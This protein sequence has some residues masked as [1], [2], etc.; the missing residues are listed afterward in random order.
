MSVTRRFGLK[1]AHEFGSLLS[2]SE[3]M[4]HEEDDGV[5]EAIEAAEKAIEGL[6]S[7]RAPKHSTR[8]DRLKSG[9]VFLASG[10]GLLASLG[11]LLK[12]CDHSVTE[13]AYN[14]LSES[15]VKLSDQEQK[16]QQDV[17][18]I[19]GYLDGLSRAPLPPPSPGASPPLLFLAD[20]G[21]SFQLRTFSSKPEPTPNI[22]FT[23]EPTPPPP[24]QVHAPSAPVKPP[25]FTAATK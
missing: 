13:S 16:T 12:T 11:A 19:R 1:K 2:Y 10:A 18:S 25:S 20:A 3:Q 24:P 5:A 23:Y 21:A 14:T 4:P 8:S 15:I 6:P 9:A 17:S 7:S 22:T